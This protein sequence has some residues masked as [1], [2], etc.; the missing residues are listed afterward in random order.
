MPAGLA[1]RLR[2]RLLPIG[3]TF[4]RKDSMRAALD[5]V[6]TSPTGQGVCVDEN[7]K[8]VGVVDHAILAGVLRS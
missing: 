2:R 8:A 7:G 1:E 4:T 6:L 3:A 5:A